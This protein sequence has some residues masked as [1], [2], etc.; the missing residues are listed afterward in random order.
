MYSSGDAEGVGFGFSSDSMVLVL[1]ELALYI[2]VILRMWK[3][4]N[5]QT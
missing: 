2:K 1:V 3:S 5:H 4:L